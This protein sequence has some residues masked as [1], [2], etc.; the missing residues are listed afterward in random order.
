VIPTVGGPSSVK[1]HALTVLRPGDGNTKLKHDKLMFVQS[2]G[3]TI[4]APGGFAEPSEP[5]A[6]RPEHGTERT[7]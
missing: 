1:G 6:S 4:P 3:A 7:A 2:A 5:P